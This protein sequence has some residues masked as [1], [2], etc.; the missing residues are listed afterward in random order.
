MKDKDNEENY[1]NTIIE[2]INIPKK[3][4]FDEY[5]K[6]FSEKYNF[7]Y[8]NLIYNMCIHVEY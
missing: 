5:Y 3:N 4:E 8:N 6:L 2:Y 7:N 1:F